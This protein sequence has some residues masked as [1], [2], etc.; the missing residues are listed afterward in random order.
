MR[1]S[2][3]GAALL[4]AAIAALPAPAQVLPQRLRIPGVANAAQVS[5]VLYRGA[6]PTEQGFLELRKLGVKTVLS[7]RSAHDDRK[8][9]RGLGFYTFRIPARQ[10][11]PETEDVLAA[12]K[13]IVT[14]S[15][16]PVFVHCQAG[17]DR[18]GLV[19]ALY[20]VLFAGRSVDDA[21]AERRSYGALEIWFPNERYLE[22]LRDEAFRTWLLGRIS[23]EPLPAVVRVP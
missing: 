19:V 11:H 9:V 1:A 7:M 6:Q 4:L 15:L 16:Q 12:L 22:R 18:T 10:W 3:V 20:E 21:I 17:K 14:P 13:V 8:L 23:K 2:R 5:S